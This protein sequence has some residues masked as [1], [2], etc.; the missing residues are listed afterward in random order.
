MIGLANFLVNLAYFTK[1]LPDKQVEDE[2]QSLVHVLHNTFRIGGDSLAYD[3]PILLEKDG[4]VEYK[5]IGAFCEGQGLGQIPP[6]YRALSVNAETGLVSFKPVYA[7]IRHENPSKFVEIELVTGHKIVVTDNHSM[8]SLG[9]DGAITVVAPKDNPQNIIM[10]RYFNFIGIQDCDRMFYDPVFARILGYYAAWGHA[11]GDFLVFEGLSRGQ[12]KYIDAYFSDKIQGYQ[13]RYEKCA[14][15]NACNAPWANH[16]VFVCAV[17]L[18]MASLFGELCGYTQETKHLP[19]CEFPFNAVGM[20]FVS[21]FAEVSGLFRETCLAIGTMSPALARGLSLLLLQEGIVHTKKPLILGTGTKMPGIVG[22]WGAPYEVLRIPGEYVQN[23]LSF[24]SEYKTRRANQLAP[25]TYKKYTDYS[26]LRDKIDKVYRRFGIAFNA[27][28]RRWMVTQEML[29]QIE[30]DLVERLDIA[31]QLPEPTTAE[32]ARYL[33][34]VL[35]LPKSAYKYSDEGWGQYDLR[36]YGEDT[37]KGFLQTV[38]VQLAAMQELKGLVRKSEQLLPIKVKSITYLPDQQYSYD[39][40]VEG[41]ENFLAGDN[42]LAH[43]SPFT[44]VSL[45]C[46]GTLQGLFSGGPDSFPGLYPDGS[47]ILDNVDEIMRVQ[48][49]FAEFIA[50]GAPTGIP[51]RFPVE[52]AEVA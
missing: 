14:P 34:D 36:Y 24:V 45:F 4:R 5:S 9:K 41:N 39:I 42:M 25:W 38:Q 27:Y 2:I 49:L 43:N 37:R 19:Q 50:K 46:R 32:E 28:G 31:E 6:G 10:P 48:K 21:G 51:Y 26:G 1:G 33:A 22:E 16:G 12:R 44:N 17:G 7:T 18:E 15:K 47:L 52:V 20:D 8:L 13:S 11:D 30:R 23:K 35:L 40:S 3:T 29:A